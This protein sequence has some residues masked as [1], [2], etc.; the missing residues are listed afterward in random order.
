MLH[1]IACCVHY[2]VHI[3]RDSTHPQLGRVGRTWAYG[4]RFLRW[5]A[6]E[7]TMMGM[8]P[9]SLLRRWG[10]AFGATCTMRSRWKAPL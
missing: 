6:D 1:A 2:Q 7:R 3:Y 10:A 4:V 9:M 5:Q 8:W